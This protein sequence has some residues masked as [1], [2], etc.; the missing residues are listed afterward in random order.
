MHIT[1]RVLLDS[2]ILEVERFMACH[3]CPTHSFLRA[4]VSAAYTHTH[5]PIRRFGGKFDRI[6]VK[7]ATLRPVLPPSQLLHSPA[8]MKLELYQT[9]GVTH[10]HFSLSVCHGDLE[11]EALAVSSLDLSYRLYLDQEVDRYILEQLQPMCVDYRQSNSGSKFSNT[12]EEKHYYI[13]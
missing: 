5:T 7:V 9:S 8:Y 13:I 1:Y 10:Q 4:A 2:E 3:R 11:H 12:T 6:W